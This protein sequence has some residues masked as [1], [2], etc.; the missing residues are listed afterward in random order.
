MIPIDG[1]SDIDSETRQAPLYEGELFGEMSC[2][3]RSPRSATVVA[4]G[5]CYLLEMVRNVLDTLHNDPKYKLRMDAVYRERVLE[6]HIR[7][8]SLF[9]ELDEAEFS[10][11]REHVELVDFESGGVICEEFGESDCIYVIRSGV[12]K[13]VANAW[14]SLRMAEFEASDWTVI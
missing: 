13:V 1:P 14:T 2:M 6:G 11:L 12:V 7:Q 10:K 4:T 3:N 9:N 8:L 5:Q